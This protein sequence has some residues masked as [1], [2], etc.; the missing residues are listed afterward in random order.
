MILAVKL[1]LTGATLAYG[2]GYSVRRR[3]NSL[4]RMV[5]P[6]GLLLSM[7]IPVVVAVGRIR[8]G[9]PYPA[10]YW[11]VRALETD[12]RV[13]GVLAVHAVV[14]F[15]AL[16]ALLAQGATGV[17]RSPLHRRLFPYAAI[18]WLAAYLGGM[19]LLP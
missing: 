9:E 3:N 6:A 11:L 17:L 5:M 7:A 4:H 19:F 14:F 8:F 1:L 13:N 12:G 2:I 15:C 10:A 16:A 18:L